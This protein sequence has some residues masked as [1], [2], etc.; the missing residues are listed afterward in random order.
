MLF[1]NIIQIAQSLFVRNPSAAVAERY[2]IA[3]G[4]KHPIRHHR[5]VIC[6][7]LSTAQSPGMERC[8]AG[9]IPGSVI[10]GKC[11]YFVEALFRHPH[12]HYLRPDWIDPGDHHLG[13]YLVPGAI[14]G[15]RVL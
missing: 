1:L 7:P 9:G 4:G 12:Q 5:S 3:A 11:Q 8:L 14:L 13:I 6:L 15:G 10:M 2:R